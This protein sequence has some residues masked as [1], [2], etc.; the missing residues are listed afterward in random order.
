MILP[1]LTPKE[2]WMEFIAEGRQ[3]HKTALGGINRP[4][5][6]T[7]EILYNLFAMAMEKYIMGL[8][9][10][11]K[12]L[13]DNHTFQDLVDGLRRMEAQAGEA[14]VAS[15]DE[16]LAGELQALDA[17]QEICS[18][19]GYARRAPNEE[20]ILKMSRTCTKLREYVEAGLPRESA[21]CAT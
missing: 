9:M 6:F 20:E 17:F 7:P 2:S 1:R 18:V 8:L 10:F 3:F 16:E 13:P 11:R 14:L 5:V 15:L 12:N 21:T 19:E 4:E